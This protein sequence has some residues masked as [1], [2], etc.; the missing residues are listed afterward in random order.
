V[1]FACPSRTTDE[2]G[3]FVPCAA[4]RPLETLWRKTT[5]PA[6]SEQ[7][8]A[9]SMSARPLESFRRR[10]CKLIATATS[11]ATAG[12]GEAFGMKAV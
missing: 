10:W 2:N 6:P 3:A 5:V 7:A 9:K 11:T 12:I 4:E 1:P 8:I